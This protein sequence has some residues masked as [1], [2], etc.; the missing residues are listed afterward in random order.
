MRTLFLLLVLSLPCWA[1][2]QG[3]F[4]PAAGVPGTT[5]IHKDSAVFVGWAT[6]I[7]LIRGYVNIA[8]TNITYNGTNKASFGEPEYALGKA[9]GNSTLSVSL[10]DGGMATLGFDNPIFNG[11]GPDFAIFE[12][13]FSDTYLELAFVEVSS[14]GERFVRFPSVSLTPTHTQTGGFANTDPTQIHNLAGKYRVGYGTPFDLDDLRDSTGIDLNHIRFVRIIDVVGCIDCQHKSHDSNG[15]I[16]NDPWPTAFH[17]GGFDLEA[18]GVIH[19]LQGTPVKNPGMTVESQMRVYP[20]P[21]KEQFW[22]DAPVGSLIRVYNLGGNCVFTSQ[23]TLP[24]TAIPLDHPGYYIVVVAN[25]PEVKTF[26]L[27]KK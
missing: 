25:G 18:V 3:P 14:D 8:D 11:P 2:G 20:N 27:I 4:A 21:A 5:A 12:N 1:W 23:L 13:S 10:G 15:N 19:V 26:R 22:V 7:E 9:T 6:S 24:T 16:I 17:S